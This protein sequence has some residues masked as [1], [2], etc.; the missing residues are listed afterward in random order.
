MLNPFYKVIPERYDKHGKAKE[1]FKMLDSRFNTEVTPLD[2]FFVRARFTNMIYEV[3]R[4]FF[5]FPLGVDRK[6]PLSRA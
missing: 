4:D 2:H 3:I 1:K 5:K 6:R